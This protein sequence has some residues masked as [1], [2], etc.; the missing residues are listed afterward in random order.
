[1]RHAQG[2]TAPDDALPLLA[3]AAPAL[4]VL[5]TGT[6]KSA[7]FADGHWTLDLAGADA[8]AV[9]DF[10]ARMRAAG[11]PALVATSAAGTRVRFG[12]P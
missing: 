11:V 5:P 10:D 2:L 9:G 4:A 6:V 12:G 3:R 7:S 1:L 8:A